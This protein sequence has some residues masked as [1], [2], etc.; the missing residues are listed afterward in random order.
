MFGPVALIRRLARIRR[1]F[2]AWALAFILIP[3]LQAETKPGTCDAG[4]LAPATS[5]EVDTRGNVM[6]QTDP[7][8]VRTDFTWNEADWPVA[9]MTASSASTGNVARMKRKI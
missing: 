1:L 7:R 8:G 4:G 6:E 9:V 5:F 3:K 2:P